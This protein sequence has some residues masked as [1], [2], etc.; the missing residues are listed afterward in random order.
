MNTLVDAY[1]LWM[2]CLFAVCLLAQVGSG[3]LMMFCALGRLATALFH[4]FDRSSHA[5]V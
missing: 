1:A 3:V 5:N 4:R 2:C